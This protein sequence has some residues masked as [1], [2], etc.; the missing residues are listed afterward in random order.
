VRFIFPKCCKEFVM[1]YLRA[2]MIK[3]RDGGDLRMST[4]RPVSTQELSAAYV[5]EREAEF[6]TVERV[7]A[8]AGARFK[9]FAAPP[10]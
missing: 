6:A 3:I 2:V 7:I 5:H 9:T 10:A 8:E 4:A 1:E